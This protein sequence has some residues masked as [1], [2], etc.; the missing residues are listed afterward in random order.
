[1]QAPVRIKPL[2][3]PF[4]N[5]RREAR[6]YWLGEGSSVL[7][8]DD[9][10][11]MGAQ[12]ITREDRLRAFERMNVPAV[13]TLSYATVIRLGQ[14][15]GATHVV[16]G[17]FELQD[18]QLGVRAKAIRLDTGRMEPEVV[19]KGPLDDTFGIY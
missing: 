12:A 15:V 7:L 5:L 17:S 2:V 14:L 13:A 19:E 11:A 4:E 9:L 3:V 10:L 16:V 6:L 18:S 1:A 8:T